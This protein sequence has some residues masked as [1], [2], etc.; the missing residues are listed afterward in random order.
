M[1]LPWN[2][3]KI[4][5]CSGGGGLGRFD[6]GFGFGFG[7]HCE[8]YPHKSCCIIPAN[9]LFWSRGGLGRFDVGIS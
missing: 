8:Q 7:G 9:C 1:L 6:F 5:C 3:Y 2:A 4:V